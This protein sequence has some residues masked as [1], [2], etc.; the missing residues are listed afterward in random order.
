M[1]PSPHNSSAGVWW[2]FLAAGAVGYRLGTDDIDMLT[3]F[4]GWTDQR[5]KLPPREI[6]FSGG[7]LSVVNEQ[8]DTVVL[9]AAQFAGV[10]LP[11]SVVTINAASAAT[12]LLVMW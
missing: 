6:F 2:V 1:A 4:P 3:T 12:H 7:D 5:S 11:I 8:G 10:R 9:N